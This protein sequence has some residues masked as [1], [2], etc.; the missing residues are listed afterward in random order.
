M[1]VQPT[2]L[3]LLDRRLGRCARV[4]RSP[5]IGGRAGVNRC[6]RVGRRGRAGVDRRHRS[7]VSRRRGRG[8]A[9]KHDAVARLIVAAGLKGRGNQLAVAGIDVA[10]GL[11]LVAGVG[12]LLDLAF[13]GR[14]LVGLDDLLR[15]RSRLL[16]TTIRW[17]C[18][19]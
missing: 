11:D 3:F 14:E 19:R 9:D 7:G 17:R 1:R 12:G 10:I 16:F 13:A 2:G 5:R 18:L 6:C 15:E 4:G 8:L